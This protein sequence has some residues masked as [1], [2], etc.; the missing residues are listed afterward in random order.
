[1]QNPTHNKQ[2][3]V[4]E[5]KNSLS[6]PTR[7]MD[8]PISAVDRV[9]EIEKAGLS[10]QSHLNAKLDIIL[11]QI[12]NLQQE[13]K[14]IIEQAEEDMKLHQIKCNFE[15][16]IGMKIHCYMRKNGENFFSLLSPEEWQNSP[17]VFLAT[18]LIK[19][20]MGFEKINT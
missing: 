3:P 17:A 12:Q 2:E 10:V 15:K 20:D 7:T 4:V 14:K 19:P 9:K 6:Y 18:Y 1:M 8:P 5:N 13:A 11:H 16:R